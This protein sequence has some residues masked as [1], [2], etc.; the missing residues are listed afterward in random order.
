MFD[1]INL[2]QAL[3]GIYD[4]GVK[5]DSMNLIYKANREI[6]MAVN[7]PNQWPVSIVM[8]RET[9]TRK[10]RLTGGD[11][12]VYLGL[13]PGRY[14]IRS[15]RNAKTHREVCFRTQNWIQHTH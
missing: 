9:E 13:C 15:P 6:M 7:T 11:L 14:H 5:D 12:G 4:T 1:A 3:S 8:V 10:C 2:E